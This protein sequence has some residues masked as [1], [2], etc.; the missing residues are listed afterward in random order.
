LANN[1][2]QLPLKDQLKQT[3]EEARV[4][5]PGI[6]ALFGFQ[7]IAVFNESFSKKLTEGEQRLHLWAIGL[8]ALAVGLSMGT[9]ALHRQ[10]QPESVSNRLVKTCTVLL[11]VA[12]APLLVGI[13]FDFY[14]MCRMILNH[15]EHARDLAILLGAILVAIWYVMPY[16]IRGYL[17]KPEPENANLQAVA[18]EPGERSYVA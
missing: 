11:T 14:L 16:A 12:M 2:E 7:L 18:A 8:T 3:L 17:K 15:T 6:Q 13:V 5:L 1:I 10:S 9:T 4:V